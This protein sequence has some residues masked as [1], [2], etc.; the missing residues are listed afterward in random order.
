MRRR[1]YLS[2]TRTADQLI[3]VQGLE[4]KFQC[5]PLWTELFFIGPDS[6]I[7]SRGARKFEI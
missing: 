7:L 6:A 4:Q 3:H 5:L 2:I 1:V